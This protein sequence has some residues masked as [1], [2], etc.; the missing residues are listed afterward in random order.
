MLHTSEWVKKL[1]ASLSRIM[2]LQKVIRLSA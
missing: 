1:T 2:S